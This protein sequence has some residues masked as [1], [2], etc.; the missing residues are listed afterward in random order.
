MP[1]VLGIDEA[2]YGPLL[3]PLVIGATLWRCSPT[4]VDTDHWELLSDCV[5]RE[6]DHRGTRL[7]VGDSKQLY[8]RKRGLW[9]LER[10]VLAFARATGVSCDY[11]SDF[12]SGVG[13]DIGTADES[14]PWY[15]ELSRP[16]PT[17][18]ARS[19]YEGAAQ[20]LVATM[21]TCGLACA[22]LRTAVIT[23]D[24]FNARLAQTHN[25]SA[26]LLET[27]LKLIHAAGR[28]TGDQ[29][30]HVFV[31][32]LGG[33]LDYRTWL[34]TAFPDRH[35]HLKEAPDGCSCYRLAG[36]QNDWHIHFV[37]DGDRQH[38]P[39]ALASMLAKYVRELLMD[40]F[41]AFW[42]ALQPDLRPTAGYYAD[43]RRFLADIDTLLPRA[44]VPRERF[45]R[46]R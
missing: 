24:V 33:R 18:P 7:G 10:S 46:A 43:A 1:W 12:L 8:D 35:L 14:F 19:A 11:L 20:K 40:G 13:F 25:K 38:L 29:D 45:V 36:P 44:G 4:I 41:N 22:H 2:G 31:D 34:M 28:Q 5:A 32:R 37:T 30:L 17:D 27:V 6:I 42:T 9:T 21:Q 15:R 3:G 16:L 26:V 39:I 23:E